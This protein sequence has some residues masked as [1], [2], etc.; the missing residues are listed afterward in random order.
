M[1]NIIIGKNEIHKNA[2]LVALNYVENSKVGKNACLYGCRIINSI[3]EENVV[4]TNSV[5][6]NS[7]I[8]MG[9]TVGPFAYLREN[10]QIGKNCRIGDFVEI[11]NSKIKDGTKCAHLA[12]VGDA[13][14]GKNCNIG[15]GTVFAN[16]NKA[17]NCSKR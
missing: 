14:V 10:S 6:E 2:K 5:I 17:K 13:S 12:Y 16:Y 1:E 15:C 7:V 3:I 8:K 9:T 11:K 4:A